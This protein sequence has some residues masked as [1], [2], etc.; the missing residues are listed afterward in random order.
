MSP[1]HDPEQ[2]PQLSDQPVD[3]PDLEPIAVDEVEP[4]EAVDEHEPP[5]GRGRNA[6]IAG[7][8]VGVIAGAALFGIRTASGNKA[9][10]T[11]AANNGGTQTQG[12]GPSGSQR[13]PGT[14]GTISSISGSTLTVKG[15]D[16][17][18]TDVNTTSATTVTKSATG[19]LSDVKVGDHVSVNGTGTSTQ[20]AAQRVTDTGSTAPTNGLQGG[21]PGGGG[22]FGNGGPPNGGNGS[23]TNTF[24]GASGTVKSISGST[25]TLQ[26]STG[27]TVTATTSSTTTVSITTPS[28]VSAL[29]VGDQ[30]LVVGSTSNNVV[31]ATS[32]R[33]G[34]V[35]G[36]FF[37][38]GPG[39]GNGGP[40]AGTGTAQQSTGQTT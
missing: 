24:A 13:R 30:V 32:I 3:G 17:T 20:I 10:A 27:T 4:D 15:A 29:A 34:S 23:G 9:A 33:E 12:L 28:T 7:I 25:L 11:P 37:R 5:R 39:G 22:G 16:G 26:T 18:S 31:T 14:A 40:G 38:G 35:G 21:R 19:A 6:I 2:D 8:A 36:G 1:E